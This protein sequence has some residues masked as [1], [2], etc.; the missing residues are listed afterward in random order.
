[1]KDVDGL[2]S[3]YFSQIDDRE[4]ETEGGRQPAMVEWWIYI[5]IHHCN[6]RSAGVW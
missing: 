6:A 1:M 5:T 2:K 3:K 4:R